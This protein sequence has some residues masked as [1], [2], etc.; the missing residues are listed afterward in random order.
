MAEELFEEQY[1][2]ILDTEYTSWEGCIDTG[3]DASNGQYREIVQ[4]AS[5]LVETGSLEIVDTFNRFVR[6]QINP[7]LS[8]YFVS[9][10]GITQDD[11][12]DE[13]P[14]QTVAD[15]F[16]SWLGEY[17]IYAWGNE[18]EVLNRNAELYEADIEFSPEQFRDVRSLLAQQG[19]P[20]D[21]YT[22]GTVEEYFDISLPG[23]NEH[24][25]IDDCRNLLAVLGEVEDSI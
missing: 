6:P 20:V 1:I 11:I 21:E 19:V 15:S 12:A 25:A 10:T 8:E 23:T 4:I 18:V 2:Y 5:L 24:N 9:L 14:F 3:W 22:S 16:L 7:T 13:D 17:R